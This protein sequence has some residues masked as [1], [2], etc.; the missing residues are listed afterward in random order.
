[1]NKEKDC[2]C[3]HGVSRR[4]VLKAGLAAAATAAIGLGGDAP[5]GKGS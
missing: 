4:G 2:A 3:A 5:G 1:M